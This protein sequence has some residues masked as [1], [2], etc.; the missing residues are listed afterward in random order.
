MK[1]PLRWGVVGLG[2]VASDYVVPGI[3]KSPDS[4][5][6][7][8]LGSTPEKTRAFAERFKVPR[9]H[10]NLVGLVND[11]GVDAIYIA[12]PNAM[13]HE[14]VI[15]AARAGKHILCEK[16]FAMRPDHAR[17][18]AATCREAGIVL[19]IAHQIRLDAAVVRARE[20]VQSGRL[21]RLAEISL[22]RASAVGARVSWRKDFAQSGVI[23]DVG[24]HLL[25]LIQY[26]S[27]QRFIEV[28]AFTH[29][30]RR[31][32][33]PDD[34]VTVLGRLEGDCHALAKATREV[35]SAENNLIIEGDKATLVTSPLRFAKEHLI[36]IRDASGITE[37][38]FPV[39]PAYDLQ[40]RAFENDVRGQRSLL[41]DADD[42]AYMVAVT[43]AVLQSV[44]ERRI[45]GVT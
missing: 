13:H 42:G 10:D 27:G 17:E 43:S 5:L 34:T 11:D 23:F 38:K 36:R 28:A 7:A 40:V 44:E 39:S 8:C 3:I 21:G 31:K 18:M 14:A 19:R 41:P 22:E 2:W 29:P 26:V 4:E 15:A 45:V 24:V 20:I 6:A 33:L 32:K 37:E 9:G 16:P 12:T 35:G 25:D 30:D 1:A